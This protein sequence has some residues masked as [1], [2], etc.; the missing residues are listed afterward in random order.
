MSDKSDAALVQEALAG[1]NQAFCAL[2]QRYK[3]AVFGSAVARL[4]DFHEAEEAAQEAFVRAY[5][6]LAQLKDASKFGSWLHSI[7]ANVCSN[8]VR[9]RRRRE[10]PLTAAPSEESIADS[11]PLP[12]RQAELREVRDFVLR[13]IGRL[14]EGE[15]EATTLYYVNGYTQRDIGRFLGVPHGTVRRRLHS[16]RQRLKDE[17]VGLVETTLKEE[18]PTMA[19]TDKVLQDALGRVEQAA[20]RMDRDSVIERCEETLNILDQMPKSPEHQSVRSSL[21]RKHASAGSE[22]LLSPSAD[23]IAEMREALRLATDAGD[24]AEAAESGRHLGLLLCRSDRLSQGLPCLE[25]AIEAAERAKHPGLKGS[26]FYDLVGVLILEGKRA[27]ASRAAHKYRAS[28]DESGEPSLVAES[29]AAM[30]VVNEVPDSWWQASPTPSRG[31]AQSWLK[32]ALGKRG[33]HVDERVGVWSGFRELSKPYSPLL[34]WPALFIA[35]RTATCAF[36]ITKRQRRGWAEHFSSL[37][38]PGITFTGDSIIRSTSDV[39]RTPAGRFEGCIR[40][41]TTIG[42]VD[43][44]APQPIRHDLRGRR[45]IWLAPGVGLVRVRFRFENGARA[46][47]ELVDYSVTGRPSSCMPLDEGNHWRYEQRSGN[48]VTRDLCRVVRSVPGDPGERCVYVSCANWSV[49]GDCG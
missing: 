10:L 30:D 29:Q 20:Q 36:R 39:V 38:D 3:E 47:V 12:D 37:S 46:R 15:R 6:A 21:I 16:A 7:T 17:V 5:V 14:P 49:G 32:V 45:S 34:G 40:I 44:S 28:A 9:D 8:W 24:Y 19:F 41:D 23:A 2:V 27:K 31:F 33:V 25:G 18:A 48:V 26:A 4:G 42:L 43:E 1:A 35:F 13:A 11:A 22:W